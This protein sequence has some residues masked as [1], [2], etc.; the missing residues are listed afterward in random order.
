[1]PDQ[2]DDMERRAR[3]AQEHAATSSDVDHRRLHDQATDALVLIADA[4]RLRE[5]VAEERRTNAALVLAMG[6]AMDALRGW[7]ATA[8]GL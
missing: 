5:L 2:W 4:R 3:T 6:R 8:S 1:M 7:A